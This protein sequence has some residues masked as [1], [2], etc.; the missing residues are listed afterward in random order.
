MPRPRSTLLLL[1]AILLVG[2]VARV[3]TSLGPGSLWHDELPTALNA[4]ER[5]WDEIL[6]PLGYKQIAPLGFNAA[7]KAAV[8]LAGPTEWGLRLFPLLASVVALFLFWRVAARF[9]APGPLLGAL[10]LFAV[11]PALVWYARKAKQYAGDLGATLLLLWLALRAREEGYRRREAWIPGI[12]GGVAIVVSHPAVLVAVGLFAAL[13]WERWR[14][15]R[16]LVPLLPLAA[17]WTA[18]LL[19]QVWTTT[20]LTPTETHDFMSSAWSF[21]FFPP[22][23][24]SLRAALWLPLRI[25][26]YMGFLVGL[27]E[28]DSAWE[29]GF[30]GAYFALAALGAAGLLRRRPP[31]VAL[32]LVPLVVAILASAARILPLSGRLMIYVA[33]TIVVACL[34]GLEEIRARVPTRLHAGVLRGGLVL[35]AAP[36]L[37]LPLMIP[38]LNQQ[39]DT[40]PVLREVRGR[41][42]EGDVVLVYGGAVQAMRFYGP[43]LGFERWIEGGIYGPDPRAYLRDVDALRGH[44]RAWFFQSHSLG[45]SVPMMHSYLDSIGTGI[46]AVEDPHGNRGMHQA[47]ARLYDLSDPGLLARSSA[48]S[49]PLLDRS[50]PRCHDRDTSIGGRIKGKLRDLLADLAG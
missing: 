8:A 5:G 19:V 41:W 18:G 31:G 40:R 36:A 29:I 21:A 42:R 33:P 3:T 15:G 23:W 12:A 14:D 48:A 27:M 44:P 28:A 45:C 6:T 9:L 34:A 25:F 1:V 24:E 20:L 32:L 16:S 17:G 38:V 26:D 37:F 7:E 43:P 35:A 39:D 4:T 10:A 30:V 47:E 46:E 49:H 13:A 2:I 11:S 22:P 50:D